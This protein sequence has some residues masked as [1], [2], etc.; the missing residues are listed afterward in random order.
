MNDENALMRSGPVPEG[1]GPWRVFSS[2]TGE[3]EQFPA[4]R[5][6][7]Q[8]AVDAVLRAGHTPSNGEE[9]FTS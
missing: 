7:V 5:P 6:Y 1:W 9:R 2:E 8:V 3:L 4:Q